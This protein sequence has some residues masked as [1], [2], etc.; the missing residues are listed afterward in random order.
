MKFANFFPVH[1]KF[2]S[3]DFVDQSGFKDKNC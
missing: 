3:A 1:L 2:A